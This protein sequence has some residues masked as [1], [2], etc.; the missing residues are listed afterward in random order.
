MTPNSLVSTMLEDFNSNR[1]DFPVG[2][3][4]NNNMMDQPIIKQEFTSMDVNH[5]SAFSFVDSLNHQES[6]SMSS[7]SAAHHMI[8]SHINSAS[9]VW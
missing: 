5:T 9:D 2:M 6:H 8:P 7:Y 4:T 1:I 3:V